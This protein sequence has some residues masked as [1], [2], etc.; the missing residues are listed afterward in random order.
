MLHIVAYDIRDSR[1]LKKLARL[2]LDYGVRVQ[3]SIFEF[4]L[5]PGPMQDFLRELEAIIDVSCDRVMIVPVC[6]ACRE[7]IRL[8]GQAEAYTLPHLYCF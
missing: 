2:C 6:A 7:N 4:D 8:L 1:R 3:Y 5:E